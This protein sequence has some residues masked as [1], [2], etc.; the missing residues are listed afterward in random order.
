MGLKILYVLGALLAILLLLV[1]I[2]PKK[3]EM[4]RSILIN[5]TADQVFPHLKFFAK[6]AAWSPWHP[7]D[8]NIKTSIEGIDGEVGAVSKWSGNDK[9]GEGQEVIESLIPNQEVVT[10]TIFI[11]PWE[12]EAE[13]AVRLAPQGG[14]TKVTWGFNMPMKI[15]FN[16][17]GLFMDMSK[18]IAADYDRGLAN[19][20]KLVEAEAEAINAGNAPLLVEEL[21][22]P[23]MQYLGIRLT[24]PF[25]E[26][27]AKSKA[28][29][30]KL[31]DAL[32]AKGISPSGPPRSLY[33]VWDLEKQQAE[34][35]V[36][37]PV[38]AKADLGSGFEYVSFP[39][40][41]GLKVAYY[42]EYGGTGAAH[43]ALDEYANKKGLK[44]K[45]P[46]I[47][48][49]YTDPSTQADPKKWLT[50]VLYMLE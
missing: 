7:L 35:M 38:T 44:I 1:L 34:M 19:L 29:M 47:E 42:G 48:E 43:G 50:N 10:K 11:K 14:Q 32:K 8:P 23:A 41:K 9:V 33:Y 45:T 4:E 46:V 25:T 28:A 31:Q 24:A 5:A 21:D 15:P 17:M 3:L 27:E 2:A 20:K 6:R 16:V 40:S 39:V 13:A 30:T 37:A 36:T 12:S 49:Y 18:S 26:L 22:L